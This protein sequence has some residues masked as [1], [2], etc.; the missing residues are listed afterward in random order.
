MSL[1]SLHYHVVFS[2]KDRRPLINPAIRPDLHAY[3]GGIVREL[4][5]KPVIIGGVADH[6]HMLLSLPGSL[7]V[8]ECLRVVK[9][10][11][12]RWMNERGH[13]FSWQS[14][15]SAFTVST[16]LMPAVTDYIRAQEE[17][18]KIHAFRDELLALLVKNGIAFDE[19]YLWS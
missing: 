1:T 17:H 15:Y 12:S 8:A 18:H 13:V 9:A 2:T 11:S 7:A 3:I 5:G 16:S 6:V 14:G 4:Q 19:K 10:N